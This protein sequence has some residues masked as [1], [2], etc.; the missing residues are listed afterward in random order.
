MPYL[1]SQGIGE[2]NTDL[3]L[4]AFLRCP[5]WFISKHTSLFPFMRSVLLLPMC[6][7]SCW[8]HGKVFSTLEIQSIAGQLLFQ[9]FSQDSYCGLWYHTTGRWWLPWGHRVWPSYVQHGQ[10]ESSPKEIIRNVSKEHIC[11]HGELD[12]VIGRKMWMENRDLYKMILNSPKLKFWFK[13]KTATLITLWLQDTS[14]NSKQN[15]VIKGTMDTWELVH[16][17]S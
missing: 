5:K 9:L 6:W 12:S 3:F 10:T 7:A 14:R 13:E 16:I 8:H 17:R 11:H 4:N 2:I 1:Y 15:T